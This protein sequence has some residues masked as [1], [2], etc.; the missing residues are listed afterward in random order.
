MTKKKLLTALALVICIAGFMYFRSS[1]PKGDTVAGRERMMNKAILKGDGWTIAK[2]LELEG[3]IISG[4]YST[5]GRSTIAVF[6]PTGNGNYKFVTSTNRNDDEIIISRAA[7]KGKRYDL[8]WFNGAETEHA[9]ITYTVNGQV[10]DTLK[11]DTDDMDIIY[12]KSP[13]KEYSVHVVYY[14]DDG[15]KYE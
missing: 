14:D 1:I 13:G 3:Y 9:E 10:Q 2:E 11:Y 7:I 6:E 8:I 15:N 5:D 12:N 4:A